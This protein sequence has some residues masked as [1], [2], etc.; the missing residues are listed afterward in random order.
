[1]I[2]YQEIIR[3]LNNKIIIGGSTTKPHSTKN[4]QIFNPKDMK[5]IGSIAECDVY[6]V[7]NA[8]DS[9]KSAFITWKNTKAQERAELVRKCGAIIND[10]SEELALIMS[11]ETGKAIR[12][13]SRLE[14]STIAPTFDFYAGLALEIKGQTIPFDP[15]MLTLTT[16]EPIGVVGAIIPWNVPLLLMAMKV[17][18][19][20]VAGNTVVIKASPEASF[21]LIRAA[22]LM[23]QI[24]PKGVLNL[25]TGGAEVGKLLVSHKDISKV[26]FTGSVESGRDVYKRAAEKLIPVT[27]E[28]GG[29]S[30]L[31]ICADADIEQAVSV[32]FDGMRFTRQGQSCS[33]SSRIL[34][35]ESIHDAFIAKLLEK[36]NE[37]IIGDP[38]DEKTDIG[39][40]ISKKQYD[41]VQSFIKLAENDENL[42]LHYGAKLPDDQHLKNGLFLRPLIISGLQNDHAICQ[43]E[44]FGPIVAI[45]KWADFDEAIRMANDVEFGLAAGI[46]TKD[47]SRALQGASNLEAGFVQINQYIVF[48]PGLAFGGFKNSGLGKEASK[49]A[50]I[51]QY[52]KEKIIIIN[53]AN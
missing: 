36:L 32:A 20:L 49:D 12:T 45:L 6:D 35:H 15:K 37:N 2:N 27:L 34:I 41:K 25:V 52:T 28:L 24:L 26:A 10:H 13:E 29:K 43:Q 42:T 47:L 4:Y 18:P 9:A 5:P 50:M 17:A 19:A 33:A 14:L 44:I 51:D 7:N 16:R 31:I 39:T 53:I 8:V 3:D 30:P 22:E 46:I 23:N 1:M 48:R 11:S 38:M 21:C 40:I